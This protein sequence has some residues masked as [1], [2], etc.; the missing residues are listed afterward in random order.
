MLGISVRPE[1][2]LEPDAPLVG[3]AFIC[4]KELGQVLA[5]PL[6][7]MLVLLPLLVVVINGVALG[8]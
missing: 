3:G 5:V 6:G 7:S 4:V 8:S 2:I 1:V